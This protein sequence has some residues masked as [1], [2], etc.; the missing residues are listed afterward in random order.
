M[1][2]IF[3][4]VTYESNDTI[5]FRSNM[6]SKELCIFRKYLHNN[7]SVVAVDTVT[8]H[9]NG[10]ILCDEQIAQRVSLLP[11]AV[12]IQ[13]ERKDLCKCNERCDEC[14]LM[15]EFEGNFKSGQSIFSH[16]I[17]PLF[18]SNIMIVPVVEDCFFKITIECNR[19]FPCFHSK[20]SAIIILSFGDDDQENY[21]GNENNERKEKR[22]RKGEKGERR[23]SKKEK[24]NWE[25]EKWD[26]NRFHNFRLTCESPISPFSILRLFP[27]YLLDSY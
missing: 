22:E 6:S 23:G 19:Q 11:F 1:P 15:I 13:K 7:I 18:C 25:T 24:K 4:N 27:L 9:S 2:L 5:S 17:S 21:T 26:G 8:I 20:W 16:D 10:T 3:D 12:N 14:T